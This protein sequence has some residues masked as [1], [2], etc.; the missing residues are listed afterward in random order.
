VLNTIAARIEERTASGPLWTRIGLPELPSHF[1]GEFERLWW[2][3]WRRLG[4][5]RDSITGK[6]G[7]K[8]KTDLLIA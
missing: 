1:G 6:R 7:S 8:K 3:L 2:L 5:R 4:L